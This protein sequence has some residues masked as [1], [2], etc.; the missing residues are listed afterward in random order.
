MKKLAILAV[1]YAYIYG[2]PAEGA[3]NLTGVQDDLFSGWAVLYDTDETVNGWAHI[4][5]FYNYR[6]W[7]KEA[8]LLEITEEELRARQNKERFVKI[9]R[10]AADVLDRPDVQGNH[11]ETI[12]R[13]GIVELIEHNEN[14]WS[15]VRT[16]SGREGF[17]RTVFLAKRKDSDAFLLGTPILDQPGNAYLEKEYEFRKALVDTAMSYMGTQYRW[18]GKG[19]EGLDCS[20]LMFASYSENGYLIYRDAAIKPGFPIREI[21][22]EELN[23]G[24][25]IFFPG[26]VAMYIGDHRYI[27]STAYYPNAGV[28]INSLDPADPDFREDL[29]HK[30]EGCGSVFP[31]KTDLTKEKIVDELSGMEG[32]ISFAYKDPRDGETILF[33]EK[34]PHIAA[35]IIKLFLVGTVF[36]LAETGALDLE[37]KICI[38]KERCVPS[39]GVLNYFEKDTEMSI[40]DLAELAVI[41]SDNTAC[42]AL[43]D[44]VGKPAVDAFCEK[45]GFTGTSLNRKMFDSVLAAQGIENYVTAEDVMRFMEMVLNGTLVSEKASGEIFKIL[46]DQRLNGKIPF[47]LHNRKE[48]VTIAHKTG[49]D[50]RT[51]HDCGIVQKGNAPAE[52]ARPFI[53]CFLGNDT[54]VAAYESYMAVLSERLYKRSLEK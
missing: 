34:E 21:S 28:C 5:T 10:H 47:L 22:R 54:D 39:C 11:V 15:A 45:Y 6:G 1:P 20:G 25:L 49:E 52:E 38:A 30:I 12:P 46:S 18:G 37:E 48:K 33:R 19:Q 23:P 44:R 7:V 16:A 42:N 13:H 31:A 29:L 40:R 9:H 24:D 27:H 17:T 2:G 3:E 14:G 4:T 8:E 50:T 51:T 32:N 36:E 35:S 43:F 53:V 26:H 41:V